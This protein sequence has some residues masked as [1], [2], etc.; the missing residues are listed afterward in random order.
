[1]PA[2]DSLQKLQAVLEV[3]RKVR[4]AKCCWHKTDEFL[5]SLL[6]GKV[7]RLE[8]RLAEVVERTVDDA[9]TMNPE[10]GDEFVALA[11]RSYAD[12]KRLMSI[13]LVQIDI[14][15]E[16]HPRDLEE[17]RRAKARWLFERHQRHTLNDVD[18]DRH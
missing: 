1:M 17:L 7:L 5:H 6:F 8:T 14:L 18:P 12:M 13:D 11:E 16:G 15:F 2:S 10:Y 9:V 3:L 4:R